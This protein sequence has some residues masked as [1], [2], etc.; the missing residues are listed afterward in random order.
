MSDP[1]NLFG[2][3]IARVLEQTQLTA[4]TN[5]SLLLPVNSALLS[6]FDRTLID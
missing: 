4:L 1:Y 2:P 5:P 3:E 6:A